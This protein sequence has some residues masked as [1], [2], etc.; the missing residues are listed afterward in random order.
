MSFHSDNFGAD[1]DSQVN[2]TDISGNNWSEGYSLVFDATVWDE[3]TDW[4]NFE[5]ASNG[6]YTHDWN[7]DQN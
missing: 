7:D 1:E 5:A 6:A 2:S 4:E 3:E